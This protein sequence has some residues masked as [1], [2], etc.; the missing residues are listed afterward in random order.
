MGETMFVNTVQFRFPVGSPRPTWSEI[1]GFLKKL[2]TDLMAMETVYKTAQ[3][4]SL[5]I[6]FTSP[7]AMMESMKKNAEPRQFV[8]ASGKTIGVR[9]M[10]AGANTR[11]VRVFDLPPELTDYN[12]S[13]VI[14]NYEVIDRVVREKFPS[15]LGVDHLFTGV[16]GVY[17]DVKSSIPPT[18][19]VGEW[20]G[21]IFYEGLKDTCFLCREEGHRRDSCPQ[22]KIRSTKEKEKQESSGSC[23]YADIASGNTTT[24]V[25]QRSDDGYIDVSEEG[26]VEDNG[27]PTE[28]SDSGIKTPAEKRWK[29]SMAKLEEV[30]KAIKE[31]M[32]NPQASQRRAQFASSKSG[33]GSAPKKKIL[34]KLKS[35]ER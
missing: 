10:V 30:A 14:G 18:L 2:D 8:Y 27:P 5:F 17:M 22:R 33:S 23:S 3:D 21:R 15:D 35:N 26:E 4:R 12:L 28:V 16:R 11:Y 6:K 13:L 29:E 25:E 24:S 9:M 32:E 34:R 20:E 19:K 7:E 1:A 31:A